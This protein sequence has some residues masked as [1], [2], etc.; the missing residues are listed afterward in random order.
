MIFVATPTLTGKLDRRYVSALINSMDVLKNHGH[1]VLW[2]TVTGSLISKARNRCV[3]SFLESNADTLVFVDDDMIWEP[4]DMLKLI[5]SEH[6][7]IGGTYLQ[8]RDDELIFNK[9]LS[10]GLGVIP[11]KWL[12]GGF[13]KIEREVFETIKAK[14]DV[15]T[16]DG[17][18][19]FYQEEYQNGFVGED[20]FI[21]KLYTEAGGQPY[22]DT[23]ISL[24]HIGDKVWRGDWEEH[25]N[26][27]ASLSKA[28][29]ELKAKV[30]A[31]KPL[32][33]WDRDELDE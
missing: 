24:G 19:A 12:P 11:I 25:V 5:E 16:Y 23:S 8:K 1:D 15:T 2:F 18:T 14:L 32:E 27:T 7:M 22:L 17:I 6:S 4:L 31:M 13:I 21:C 33:S 9:P 28:V 10:E 20:V 26:S 29:E 30:D 3:H